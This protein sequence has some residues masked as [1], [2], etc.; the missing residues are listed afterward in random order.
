M[1]ELF[2]TG[3]VCS[4]GVAFIFCGFALSNLNAEA[5]FF[6]H[7]GGFPTDIATLAEIGGTSES[8]SAFGRKSELNSSG[9]W[10]LVCSLNGQ[11]SI[12]QHLP[13]TSIQS[14]SSCS[15]AGVE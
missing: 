1:V 13:W 15:M 2:D 10:E 9:I 8:I 4:H 7:Q 6:T 12:I 3:F 11:L 14:A 5:I